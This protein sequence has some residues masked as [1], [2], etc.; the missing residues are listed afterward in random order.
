VIAFASDDK[1][2]GMSRNTLIARI[3]NPV[4]LVRGTVG[5]DREAG[6][7]ARRLRRLSICWLS[8]LRSPRSARR[9]SP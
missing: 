5:D 8:K 4:S 6:G 2:L 1:L 9:G 7:R 3:E